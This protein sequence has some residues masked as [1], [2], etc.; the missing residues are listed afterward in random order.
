[1]AIVTSCRSDMSPQGLSRNA[2]LAD[3]R[4]HLVLVHKCS[5]LQYLKVL[6]LIPT[7]GKRRMSAKPAQY[8]VPLFYA[9]NRSGVGMGSLGY[10]ALSTGRLCEESAWGHILL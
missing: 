7:C 9:A 5:I 8:A 1:M 6:S 2:H 10:A 3:G 4:M